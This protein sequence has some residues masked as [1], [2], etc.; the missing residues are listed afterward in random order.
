[1]RMEAR[2]CIIRPLSRAASVMMSLLKLR[3][4]AQHE[5]VTGDPAGNRFLAAGSVTRMAVEAPLKE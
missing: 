4:L 2:V 3:A 5:I 1:M